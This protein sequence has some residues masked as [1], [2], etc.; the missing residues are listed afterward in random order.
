MPSVKEPVEGPLTAMPPE[1]LALA[2]QGELFHRFVSWYVVI[3]LARLFEFIEKARAAKRLEHGG[4]DHKFS[5]LCQACMKE[6]REL[7]LSKLG[8]DVLKTA[9]CSLCL[10]RLVEQAKTVE[11]IY[12]ETP[13]FAEKLTDHI[14]KAAQAAIASHKPKDES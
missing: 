11:G 12:F 6:A 8:P 2:Q 5:G 10:G 9:C 14:T 3:A 1:M 4:E 13:E 7:V